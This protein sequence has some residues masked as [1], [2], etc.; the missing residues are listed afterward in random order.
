MIKFEE[1]KKQLSSKLLSGYILV[2]NDNYVLDYAYGLIKKASGIVDTTMNE[3]VLPST[4][5]DNE[6]IN[7]IMT[8][9]FLSD[10]KIVCYKG[11]LSKTTQ[12]K[13]I[14]YIKEGGDTIFVINA[15]ENEDSYKTLLKYMEKVDCNK[16][17]PSIISKFV[18]SDLNKHGKKISSKALNMLL[19]YC[20]FDM[21][22]ITVECQKLISY[23]GS[24]E[25]IDDQDVDSIV[26]KSQEYNV[27]ELT[28]ALAKGDGKKAYLVLN[29]YRDKQ[30]KTLLYLI[31]NHFR[32]MF[33]VKVSKKN[34]SEY[35]S[36]LQVK[37][38]AI[39]KA[40]EQAKLFSAKRL[41]NILEEFAKLDEDLKVSVI[42]PD[43]AIDYIVLYI[44]DKK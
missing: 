43:N 26:T 7:S 27:F 38:F 33:Y 16:L 30:N 14:P 22:K 31:Y 36:L 12:E 37:E 10:K 13:L 8:I 29:Q 44:L 41:K 20:L 4:C 5:S 2:G 15:Q 17:S 21:T 23:V 24:K 1:L 39:K 18:I 35:T 6:I 32:R 11:V 9:P 42:S 28:E 34:L 19:E 25:I 3:I 40:I